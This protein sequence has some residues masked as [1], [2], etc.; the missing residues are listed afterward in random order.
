MR[1]GLFHTAGWPMVNLGD[2]CDLVSRGTA[3][4]Y[5]EDGSTYV[6][7]QRCVQWEG[8]AAKYLKRHSPAGGREVAPQAGDV[9][10]NST[11]T[12]T[13]GRSCLF[14]VGDGH[15]MVDSHV[16]VIRPGELLAGSWLDLL[17]RSFEG[18][19]YLESHCFVGSTGQV[20]LSREE[21]IR[22]VIPLPPMAEQRR[23]A[24]ILDEVDI[25]IQQSLI[26]RKKLEVVAAA[27][28]TARMHSVS[29]GD[30]VEWTVLE[31]VAHISA[32]VTLG[33]DEAGDGAMV[34]PYL[35]VA[36]VQDGYIDTSDVKTVSVRSSDVD[37]FSLAKGDVLL[38]EG[39]DLDKLG[40]GAVW[41]GR[42]DPCLHQNH[43]FKVR[44]RTAVYHPDFL[45]SYLASPRGKNYFLSVAKQTT[46]LASINSSQ[47]KNTPVP[48]VSLVEQE[49]V[50]ASV[51]EWKEQLV[52]ASRQIEKL[53]LLRSAL[54]DDLLTGKVRVPAST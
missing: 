45:A 7:G 44:C 16:T 31:E 4:N 25:Q 2:V 42:I 3:P 49:R 54:L 20:E 52:T 22:T 21:L 15:F 5:D 8:F 28:T 50:V 12:G 6:I 30:S 13:I 33:N 46:N 26:R 23:I 38:T 35:R 34:L 36:N 19:K 24:E 9:L 27:E 37:R 48:L 43:I 14:P 39:G 11:G 51:A 47:V 18:Q 41:D 53:R 32:G 29:G 40:R 1:D 17:L 10:L